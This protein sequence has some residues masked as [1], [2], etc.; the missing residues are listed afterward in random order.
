MKGEIT[1]ATR[2]MALIYEVIFSYGMRVLMNK[3][4]FRK[5]RNLTDLLTKKKWLND[6]PPDNEAA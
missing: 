4:F 3:K 1:S 2:R 6:H 5:D